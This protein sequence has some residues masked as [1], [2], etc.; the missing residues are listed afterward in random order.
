MKYVTEYR[1]AQRV[2]D[3]LDDIHQITTRPLIVFEKFRVLLLYLSP[4]PVHPLADPGTE[5]QQKQ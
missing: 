1:D 5:Q 4:L 2:R 3:V